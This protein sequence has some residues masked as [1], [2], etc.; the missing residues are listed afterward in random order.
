MS[1]F[2]IIIKPTCAKKNIYVLQYNKM[3][4]LL[5]DILNVIE[6]KD[7]FNYYNFK[8]SQLDIK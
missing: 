1:I 6:Y 2:S 8:T 3:L 7:G 5:G 4:Y